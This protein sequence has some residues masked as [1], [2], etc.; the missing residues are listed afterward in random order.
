MQTYPLLHKNDII[1][2]LEIIKT[3]WN[4]VLLFIISN[5]KRHWG[6]RCIHKGNTSESYG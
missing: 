1:H 2:Y 4:A 3:Q 5:E 6:Y